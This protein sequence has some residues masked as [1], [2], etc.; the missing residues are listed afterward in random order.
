MLG[1][2]RFLELSYP[3]QL[4]ASEADRDPFWHLHRWIGLRAGFL[5][6]RLG[7]SSNA[8]STVRM[9][10]AVLGALLLFGHVGRFRFSAFLGAFLIYLQVL[11]DFAD[12]PIARAQVRPSL[13][14]DQFDQMG[15]AV[16]RFALF[17][18]IGL[19]T[20]SPL[21]MA[22]IIASLYVLTQF[23][24]SVQGILHNPGPL[25]VYRRVSRALVGERFFVVVLPF[26]LALISEATGGVHLAAQILASAYVALAV[27]WLIVSSRY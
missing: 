10:M 2:R 19:E 6:Y 26:V 1:W 24:R 4:A 20:G 23:R 18:M 11:L 3:E 21:M 16:A 9:L 5:L 27:S 13:V 15:C 14:G 22:A 17:A 7:V 25:H 8:L 12:G